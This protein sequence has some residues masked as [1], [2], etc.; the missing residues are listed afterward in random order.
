MG[1][2]GKVESKGLFDFEDVRGIG[3]KDSPSHDLILI[4]RQS[5]PANE[6][7]KPH[8]QT[9][10]VC[11]YDPK[12]QRYIKNFEDEGGP[13]QWVRFLPGPDKKS[14]TLVFQ[15]DDLKGN[16]VLKGF[17]FLGGS[18]KQVLDAAAPQV[19]VKFVTGFQGS[20]VWCS[21]KDLPKEKG[22]S[23]H[24]F[25]WDEAKSQYAEGKTSS[26]AGWTGASIAAPATVAVA[27]EKPAKTVEAK[28][29]VSVPKTTHPS[30]NGWWDEPLDA[31]T[32][33][34][35]LN[36][37]LVPE[38]IKKGQVAVLG[39]KAKAFFS[40]LQK[41]KE[42]GKTINGLRAG[43][44]AAVASTLLDMGKKKDAAYYLKIAFSFQADN[45]DALALKEKI[46]N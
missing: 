3:T 1:E 19:Y 4:Y 38:Y 44:Y 7:D 11:F 20:E 16:Q 43:Y 13:I 39:Q 12:L 33:A 27:E 26:T 22:D 14:L 42:D 46:K 15:R 6:L 30:K 5:V 28:Q 25:S 32:A 9:L 21:S 35:K 36:T 2:D 37:E 40:E 24:V 23:E 17:A 41:M 34:T 10:V 18:M 31:Q 45:P 8:N 29:V